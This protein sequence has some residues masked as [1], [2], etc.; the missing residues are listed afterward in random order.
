MCRMGL[1]LW[2]TQ[3]HA[4]RAGEATNTFG[5][6][7]GEMVDLP[8]GPAGAGPAVEIVVVP[9]GTILALRAWFQRRRQ[10]TGAKV[11]G[12]ERRGSARAWV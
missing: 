1:D 8:A 5:V 11:Y 2:R 9:R 4:H 10:K 7:Y 3:K 6:R 12:T